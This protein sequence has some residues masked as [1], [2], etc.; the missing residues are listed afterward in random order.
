MNQ[1]CSTTYASTSDWIV[2]L[3]VDEFLITTSSE[4]DPTGS[5]LHAAYAASKAEP[6]R[7][8]TYPIYDLLSTLDSACV[9]I[10]ITTF[11]NIGIRELGREDTVLEAHLKRNQIDANLGQK[12]C[13]L[14]VCTYQA[15]LI[16]S[17]IA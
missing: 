13:F 9:P 12:V 16:V 1:H 7:G 3:D 15:I 10:P 11:R 17:M 4:L 14:I 6:A 2:S 8:S 5:T